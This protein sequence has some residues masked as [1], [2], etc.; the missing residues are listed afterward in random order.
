MQISRVNTLTDI[1]GKTQQIEIS[2]IKY[3]MTG[4]AF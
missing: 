1:N 4:Y 2:V 3:Y